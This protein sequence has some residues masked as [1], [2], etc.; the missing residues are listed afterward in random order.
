[1][2]DH[3]DRSEVFRY[4]SGQEPEQYP[5][6]LERLTPDEIDAIADATQNEYKCEVIARFELADKPHLSI[7]EA[8]DGINSLIVQNGNTCQPTT[9]NT[10]RGTIVHFTDAGILEQVSTPNGKEKYSY[11]LTPLGRQAAALAGNLLEFGFQN[12]IRLREILS[13]GR[14]SGEES[15]S[16]TLTRIALI[17]TILAARKKMGMNVPLALLDQ[18]QYGIYTPDVA[19]LHVASLEKLKLARTTQRGKYKLF[20]VDGR[21]ATILQQ[22]VDIYARSITGDVPSFERGIANLRQFGDDPKITPYL[23]QR[24][25]A[26]SQRYEPYD[27]DK[28]TGDVVNF[29]RSTSGVTTSELIAH[30]GLKQFTFWSRVRAI[31]ANGGWP[32][33]VKR[34]KFGK[35][36]M[37]SAGT[38][39]FL[40]ER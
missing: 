17:S 19:R 24:S 36:I 27:H 31:E 11:S 35:Q 5:T 8:R 25:V 16:S 22:L 1:M 30:L 39:I 34:S 10:V 26:T 20:S 7:R 21:Q 15:C 28:F 23:L 18:R 40:T 4:E 32:V 29:L 3:H 9:T 2:T 38:Q 37:W 6:L 13:E 12:D 14:S 33:S